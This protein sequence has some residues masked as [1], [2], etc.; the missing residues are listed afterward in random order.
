[1]L[2]VLTACFQTYSTLQSGRGQRLQLLQRRR[3]LCL[4]K[5]EPLSGFLLP[6]LPFKSYYKGCVVDNLSCTIIG[7]CTVR[8][9][10]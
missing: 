1:M 9:D 10:P 6:Y 2:E 7:G 3:C 8:E 5:E 4:S